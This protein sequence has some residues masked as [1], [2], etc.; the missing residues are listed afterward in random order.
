MH[1][2][3]A[4]HPERSRRE[5]RI[6]RE[7]T[8]VKKPALLERQYQ[9]TLRFIERNKFT[10]TL[11]RNFDWGL[12]IL[13]MGIALFGVLCIFCATAAP[14]ATG[15]VN[16][17]SFLEL[18]RTQPTYYAGLQLMWVGVGLL[19]MGFVI[20]LDYE[21]FERHANKI[22]WANIALL[23]V[24]LFMERGRGGMA[25]W[26]RWGSDMA[27]TMQPS[28]FGKL[29][30]IISLA[31]LFAARQN[32]ITTVQELLPTLAYVGLP[33]ILI[34]AQPDVGTALVYIVIFGVML[35]SSGTSY[36]LIFGILA[37]AVLMLVPLWYLMNV[38]E[39]SFRLERILVFLDPT[40]D[41]SGAGMQMN[42]ARI[43]VGS[44]GMWGKGLFSE[45]S[46]ASLN[47]IPDDYTDF[48]FAIVCEAF[49]FVGA[50][51]LV[52]AFALLMIRMV[53]LSSQAADPFG[54]YVIIGVMSMQLFHIVENVGMVVGLLPVTGIPLPFISYGGS[55][56]LT[57]MI[58]MGLVFG[59]SMRSRENRKRG[60]ARRA[61]RL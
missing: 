37:L 8:K 28:E 7:G 6:R 34:V 56:L 47:Y 46:I 21:L 38:A 14:L 57:N 30:I 55:N 26:F 51:L 29:A 42:N 41:T 48:I 32:P 4:L 31:K 53:A 61:A 10:P 5:R 54:T 15:N 44:G 12:F 1:S 16:N 33:L 40:Y 18:L 20:F 22:Y 35:F 19:V 45:G 24:V 13:L 49:G 58:G 17:L 27:R 9:R 11:L 25:G 59:I 43:A 2:E 23:T 60:K 39:N 3:E 36:K 50:G 52:L